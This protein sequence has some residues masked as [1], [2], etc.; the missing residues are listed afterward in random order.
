MPQDATAPSARR[1]ELLEAA[2]EYVLS[3]GLV[4]LSLRPL[5]AA[6]GSSPRVLVFLFGNKDGLVRAL[7][8]RARVDEL[9][10]LDDLRA[11][12][13]SGAAGLVDAAARIWVWLADE[14][15]RPVL[16]LWAEAYAQ[17]L[18][19]VDGAWTGFARSTV[20]DWL[21]VLAEF[22]P[23][24]ERALPAAVAERTVALAILRGGMLDLVATGDQDRVG[25]AVT[26]ALE[27][28]RAAESEGPAAHP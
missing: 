18:I 5:A 22:Q 3:N 26:A 15:H 6:V 12:A 4:G 17:S 19:H 28:F 10:L 20:E 13:G 11:A 21:E 8:S 24:R 7:L 9:A 25:A 2:Y 27:R 14:R 16:R 23:E 1:R